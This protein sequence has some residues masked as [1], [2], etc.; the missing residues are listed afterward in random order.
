MQTTFRHI[1]T[2]IF[3]VSLS[4]FRT[5]FAESKLPATSSPSLNPSEHMANVNVVPEAMPAITTAT[6]KKMDPISSKSMAG[7][8]ASEQRTGK[9]APQQ[10]KRAERGRKKEADK[11]PLTIVPS[12]GDKPRPEPEVDVPRKSK[13]ERRASAGEVETSPKASAQ[14]GTSASQ[15]EPRPKEDKPPAVQQNEGEAG[16]QS[17][18]DSIK[19]MINI[20]INTKNVSKSRSSSSHREKKRTRDPQESERLRKIMKSV[21]EDKKSKD[22]PKIKSLLKRIEKLEKRERKAKQTRDEPSE[23]EDTS[24]VLREL[25]VEFENEPHARGSH[26]AFDDPDAPG[27]GKSKKMSTNNF[28]A[29]ACIAFV[30]FAILCAVVM[31]ARN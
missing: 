31:F 12:S 19:N 10:E 4:V 21:N 20:T 26:G 23:Q 1:S 28:L 14:P 3:G 8:L 17:T 16:R 2:L 27:R 25:L 22:N 11:S 7:V 5:V 30:G 13:D 24:E 29:M 6:K 18:I 15:V 9:N